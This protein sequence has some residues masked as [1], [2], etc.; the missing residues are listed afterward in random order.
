MINGRLI[1]ENRYFDAATLTATTSA[2]GYP[3]TNLQDPLR[4]RRWRST[5]I[6]GEYVNVDFLASRP[7]NAVVLIDHNLTFAGTLTLTASDTPAGSDLLNSTVDAWQDLIGYGED[8]YGYLDYGGGTFYEED[9]NYMV[10]R[11]IR[12]IYLDS[13]VEAR[14]LRLAF[15]DAANADGYFEMGRMFAC[16]YI[17]MGINFSS[18]R[19]EVID[20]TDVGFTLGGQAWGVRIPMRNAITLSFD[21]LDYADK[22]WT[23]K[24]MA[25]KMGVTENFVIDCFPDEA[26]PSERHHGTLYGRFS[27]LPSFEQDSDMGFASAQRR[28]STVDL[29]FEEVL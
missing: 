23:L 3:I 12:I 29:S 13:V 20:D 8:R 1:W 14:Y 17:D 27:E 28:T 25:E 24:F 15:T 9:R 11:P 5:D 6:T 26:I 16:L 4:S 19:H 7:F 10:P 18:V 21:W 22:Y 2:T